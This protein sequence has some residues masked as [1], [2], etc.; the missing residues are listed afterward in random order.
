MR[1]GGGVEKWMVILPA[2]GLAVMVTVYLGGP[3]T[4]FRTL[5]QL[6]WNGWDRLV[7]LFRR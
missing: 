7:V 2:C 6:A 5:E 1:I 3:D 4:A